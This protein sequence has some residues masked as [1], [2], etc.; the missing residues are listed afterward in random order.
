M[1]ASS[2]ARK[3]EGQT[4]RRP[5]QGLRRQIALPGQ[6]LRQ[7]GRAL[8]PPSLTHCHQVAT[9]LWTPR[10]TAG[11]RGTSWP[12]GARDCDPGQAQLV[13]VD[14]VRPPLGG[15]RRHPPAPDV[16]PV[17]SP[18]HPLQL[19]RQNAAL[20]PRHRIGSGAAGQH[21]APA[22]PR[23]A[24]RGR[25][26]TGSGPWPAAGCG[27]RR[28]PRRPPPAAPAA[29]PSSPPC[30]ARRTTPHHAR[31]SSL[32]LICRASGPIPGAP[33]GSGVTARAADGDL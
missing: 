29:I 14:D 30:P 11:R 13:D 31:L 8:L 4:T 7:G 5:A 9:S 28:P 26:R 20:Q 33:A 19:P 25:R 21:P 23:P 22:R 17:P 27:P 32:A 12:G 6:V 1:A 10:T 2:R 3:A 24:A 18:V 16:Q 15:E